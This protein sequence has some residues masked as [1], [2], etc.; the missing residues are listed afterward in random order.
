LKNDPI[1]CSF[2]IDNDRYSCHVPRYHGKIE[3]KMRPASKYTFAFRTR[4]LP[5]FDSSP[6]SAVAGEDVSKNPSLR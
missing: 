5:D 2:F 3:I 6:P 4:G 1:N